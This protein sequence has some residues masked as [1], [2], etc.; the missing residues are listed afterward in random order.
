VSVPSSVTIARR[1][2]LNNVH[3]FDGRCCVQFDSDHYWNTDNSPVSAS[4]SVYRSNLDRLV[5]DQS[6]WWGNAF[7]PERFPSPARA[8]RR[9]ALR[10]EQQYSSRVC[11]FLLRHDCRRPDSTTFTVSTAG[12]CVQFDS[13]HYGT[14]NIHQYR[15]AERYPLQP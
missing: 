3:G 11:R 12:C 8:H 7:P 4:L 13:D 1:P 14:L 6:R 2:D 9:L 5:L 15:I 10:F